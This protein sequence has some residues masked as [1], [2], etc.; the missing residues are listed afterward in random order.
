M[1]IRGERG[2]PWCVCRVD[3]HLGME[4]ALQGL[5]EGR[6]GVSENEEVGGDGATEMA[7]LFPSG[8]PHTFSPSIQSV[9]CE[10]D[11]GAG[12]RRQREAGAPSQVDSWR[13]WGCGQ[14]GA[15][16]LRLRSALCPGYTPNRARQLRTN[17]APV[18]AG[19]SANISFVPS[20]ASYPARPQAP[21]N[22]DSTTGR[23]GSHGTHQSL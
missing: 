16:E 18:A 20:A 11:D 6:W 17:L 23:R 2:D 7:G 9:S 12:G 22:F 21:A 5:Q 10:A 14:S 1:S 8:Q 3:W 15:V 4:A 19:G 13:G